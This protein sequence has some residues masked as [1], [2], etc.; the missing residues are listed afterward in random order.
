[1]EQPGDVASGW[2][3]KSRFWD[4]QKIENS[5]DVEHRTLRTIEGENAGTQWNKVCSLKTFN[6]Y[7]FT[8]FK[9]LIIP[10]IIWF[11]LFY[12]GFVEFRRILAS[13][14]WVCWISNWRKCWVLKF[15]SFEVLGVNG[16]D[17]LRELSSPGKSGCVFFLSLDDLFMH[18][19]IL[20]P[21]FNAKLFLIL[22]FP[23]IGFSLPHSDT[24]SS[25]FCS[26]ISVMH[27][28]SKSWPFQM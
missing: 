15:W 26:S 18:I 10:L 21:L 22:I 7:S 3:G 24:G 17:T 23:A 5:A 11:I 27:I 13:L 14:G 4:K 16:N 2:H 20:V 25:I 12:T 9:F 8:V 19:Q 1:M 6:L 28:Y